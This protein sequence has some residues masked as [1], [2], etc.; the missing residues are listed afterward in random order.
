MNFSDKYKPQSIR[1]VIYPSK[2]VKD[3]ITNNIP[4]LDKNMIFYGPAGIGKTTCAN[5]MILQALREEQKDQTI[6]EHHADF[7]TG[8]DLN[9]E[10]LR[11][12]KSQLKMVHIGL[13]SR[14]VI[15]VDEAELMTTDAMKQLKVTIDAS[16]VL[17]QTT[18]IFCTNDIGKFTE[19]VQSRC[20]VLDFNHYNNSGLILHAE[21]VLKLEQADTSKANILAQGAQGDVRK[22]NEMLQEYVERV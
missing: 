10:S 17:K 16:K 20:S 12:L 5:L 3:C 22:L 19:F 14:R 6:S 11:S 21:K 15:F 4:A 18:W 9:V 1:D 7:Y 2:R 8:D 13:F